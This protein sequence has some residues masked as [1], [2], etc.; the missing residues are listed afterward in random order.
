[1]LLDL[2]DGGFF[3]FSTISHKSYAVRKALIFTTQELQISLENMRGAGR[4]TLP[5]DIF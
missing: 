4:L 3:I 5:V 2:L 1:M